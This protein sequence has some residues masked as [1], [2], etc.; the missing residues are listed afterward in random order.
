MEKMECYR[1]M[2]NSFLMNYMRSKTV[3][4]KL[5]NVVTFSTSEE[6]MAAYGKSYDGFLEGFN[7]NGKNYLS[8]GADEHTVIHELLHDFSSSFY[9]GHRILNGIQKN[10][11]DRRDFIFNEGLTDYL[12]SK[13]SKQSATSSIN[14]FYA[15]S[16]NF[17]R[18]LDGL[19]NDI[20]GENNYLFESYDFNN[21]YLLETIINTFSTLKMDA[22]G[23]KNVSI[24]YDTFLSVYLGWTDKEFN[25]L[26]SS[27]QKNMLRYYGHSILNRGEKKAIDFDY[28]QEMNVIGLINKAYFDTKM[29][30]TM[31]TEEQLQYIMGELLKGNF[32]YITNDNGVRSMLIR[33]AQKIDINYVAQKYKEKLA[34]RSYSL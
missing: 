20:F 31:Y 14:R 22:S 4:N 15:P 9:N 8:P 30:Y 3:E 2:T 7:R 29:K 23:K 19:L 18:K 34:F 17:F 12:A 28:F 32:K 16:F 33:E 10:V 1:L 24:D 21:T 26:F 27:I 5:R 6:F 25:M 11:N 13:I